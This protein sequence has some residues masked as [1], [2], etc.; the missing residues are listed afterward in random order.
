[1]SIISRPAAVGALV[2]ITLMLGAAARPHSSVSPAAPSNAVWNVAQWTY[3]TGV[4]R[5]CR[6]T[7]LDDALDAY[8]EVAA[9]LRQF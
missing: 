6:D 8:G 5:D 4:A 9:R 7:V 1:M 3:L 2:A